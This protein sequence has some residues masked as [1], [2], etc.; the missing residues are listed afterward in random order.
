MANTDFKQ[1]MKER[2]DQLPKVVQ[3]AIRSSDVAKHMRSLAES[4]KLHLDQWEILENEV[5]LTL[6][7]FDDSADLEKNIMEE[8]GV[9]A[10]VAKVLAEDISK[11]VFEPIRQELEKELEAPT[12]APVDAPAPEAVPAAAPA[13]TTETQPPVAPSTPPAPAPEGKAVRAPVSEAYKS[14]E[15]STARRAIE[16]DP[17][18]EPL[19]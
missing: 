3:D 2:F 19:Q 18:R 15:A 16:D 13:Q 7:G 4:Q 14:G 6:L 17:Y 9:S 11:T 12:R 1:Q 5:M 10:E 8:V